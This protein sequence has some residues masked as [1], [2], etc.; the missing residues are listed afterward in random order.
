MWA[1]RAKSVDN[2]PIKLGMLNFDIRGVQVGNNTPAYLF[3]GR[4]MDLN[5]DS[6]MIVVEPYSDYQSPVHIPVGGD[7]YA[8]HGVTV[9]SLPPNSI[10]QI[11]YTNDLGVQLANRRYGRNIVIPLYNGPSGAAS[12]FSAQGIGSNAGAVADAGANLPAFAARRTLY[13]Q[14]SAGT[15]TA[16]GTR[17]EYS[18]DNGV[19]WFPLVNLLSADSASFVYNLDS[20]SLPPMVRFVS[21][22]S[23]AAT[24]KLW[25]VVDL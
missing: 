13:G 9:G 10:T 25:A 20:M 12:V 19:T 23:V 5:R 21:A 17:L 4:I 1:E 24:V 3:L 11:R 22:T 16:T 18:L 6:A 2:V 14:T 8:A 15:F 7:F